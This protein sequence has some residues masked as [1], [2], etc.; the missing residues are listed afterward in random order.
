MT[1]L[2]AAL[3][4]AAACSAAPTIDERTTAI[5]GGTVDSAD[6]AVVALAYRAR[7]CKAAPEA[8]CT[9]ALIAPRAVL[10]AAHCVAGES[11]ATMIVIAGPRVDGGERIEI[12]AIDIHPDYDGVSADLAVLTLAVPLAQPPLPVRRAPLDASELGA[13]ARVVGYGIDDGGVIGVKR[14]GTARI[15]E[16][17]A[18]TIV[19]APDP[20][21]PCNGDSGGPVLLAEEI[22]GV[23]AYGDPACAASGTNTRTDIHLDTFIA[24]ALARIAA[25]A[26]GSRPALDPDATTCVACAQSEDCPRGTDCLDGACV[27]IGVEH[28]ALGARCSDDSTCGGAPCLAGLDEAACRCLTTCDD[29]AGGCACGTTGAPG[30]TLLFTLL[31]TAWLARRRR[32]G[33]SCLTAGATLDALRRIRS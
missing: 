27:A 7:A 19:L 16:L 6:D 13:L 21:L 10:T 1:R 3:V 29:D 18:T 9:G 33:W 28:G 23:V 22:A 26:P 14:Q 31:A 8:V 11:A 25:S 4:V 15:A 17:T 20:A 32:A 5:V 12:D 24:P 2:F 30:G